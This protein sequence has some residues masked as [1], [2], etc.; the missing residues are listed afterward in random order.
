MNCYVIQE[1]HRLLSPFRNILSAVNGYSAN[2]STNCMTAH[3]TL[4]HFVYFVAHHGTSFEV[5]YFGG[6]GGSSSSSS[7]RR[8]RRRGKK[9]SRIISSSSSGNTKT[10]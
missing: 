7:S 3:S 2:D 1:I 6:G 4:I 9:T 8:R 5:V 10:F